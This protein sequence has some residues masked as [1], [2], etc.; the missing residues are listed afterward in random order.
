MFV[1][2]YLAWNLAVKPATPKRSLIRVENTK[3]RICLLLKRERRKRDLGGMAGRPRFFSLAKLPIFL[4]STV[5]IKPI[6]E[7]KRRK[8][9]S[10][11][12]PTFCLCCVSLFQS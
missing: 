2:P 7:E 12:P 9:F 10:R 1:L 11:R 3:I 8:G 5:S 4:P 6:W